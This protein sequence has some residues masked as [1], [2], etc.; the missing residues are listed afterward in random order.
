MPNK[1]ANNYYDFSNN[2]LT[3]QSIL[4][5]FVLQD[6]ITQSD[7]DKLKNKY[8]TNRQIESFLIKNRIVSKDAINKA[9]SIIL[10]LPYVEIKN[11]VV[12]DELKK[13]IPEK[14]I[15]QFGIIPFGLDDGI[16][17]IAVSQPAD[18]LV[19]YQNSIGQIF[20]Q[21]NLDIE[22]YVTGESDFLEVVKQY[23]PR[24][25]LG[26]K[27]G[28][29]VL[30]VVYLRSQAIPTE[31]LEKIP[32]DFISQYRIV[33]FG[34]NQRGYYLVACEQPGSETT[35]K[36]LDFIRNENGIKLE[37]FKTSKDDIDF[38][39]ESVTGRKQ[40]VSRIAK[41]KETEQPSELS[42][43]QSGGGSLISGLFDSFAKKDDDEPEITI[44]SVEQATTT[45]E[46]GDN[47][48]ENINPDNNIPKE[49]MVDPAL[50]AKPLLNNKVADK[51]DE[52]ID[53]TVETGKTVDKIE[54][55]NEESVL[56]LGQPVDGSVAGK[57]FESKNL[58]AYLNNKSIKTEADLNE[59]VKT[60]SIPKIVAAILNFALNSRSSDVHVEPENK[61]LRVRCRI[62]GIL[63][64]VIKLPLSFHAPFVSR[65]KIMSKLKIDETRIPQDG[66]FDTVFADREVDVR[67]ST[68]PTIHGEKVVM[69]LLDKSQG[70]LS[71][72]DLG[73]QGSAFDKTIEA[74][75]KPYGVILSTGPTGSGKSTTLYAVLNRISVPGVNIVTLEDPVEY[76]IAGINQCQIKPEIGF[77]FAS[78]L[79]SIL[80]QDPN[81]IMVGEIRDAETA[82]MAVHAALTGHLV[83]STLHT[84]DTAGTLPRLIDMGVEPF[85]VTS[86]INLILAQRLVRRICPK[87]KEELKVPQKLMDQVLE[88]LNKIPAENTK[89]RE[90]IP[91]DLRLYHGRGCSECNQGFKGRVGIY[92]AMT[93]TQEI[94]D[95]AIAKKAANEIKDASIKGG[96]LTMKQD[97]IIKAVNGL[98]TI[99]EVF[100]AVVSS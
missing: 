46:Q 95:M 69:R 79:R 81:V 55:P 33:V 56:N 82:G 87:C 23:N 88:E 49:K 59:I 57:E 71:L 91:K 38:V 8:K 70:I 10:K 22:L 78:G 11:I 26:D 58:G 63:R 67:V 48:V 21:K 84:N 92:E 62:D 74:I 14:M 12:A 60:S 52:V 53:E 17:K 99:D 28:M 36:I 44:D 86:S 29:D 34:Q 6:L 37:V 66:R 47:P 25:V 13:L 50:Q 73:M 80:R 94:E 39:L 24:F 3:I 93:L 41:K 19:G 31:F 9:Y 83:L 89:D 98:T 18:L 72:E 51:S 76:D 7:A 15:K 96:M 2:I 27:T 77:S 1:N 97:G 85:L 32:L 16:V 54:V 90:L 35:K 45:G 40:A 68:L 30:P 65:I 20:Q 5:V 100:Q 42:K 61:I 43:P 4:D 64:D 75:G